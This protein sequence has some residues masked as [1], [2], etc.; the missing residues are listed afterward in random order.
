MFP[1]IIA[2]ASSVTRFVSFGYPHE[3][4]FDE[5]FYGNF[6]SHYWQG[7]YFFDQHPPFVK[8]LF[9]ALGQVFGVSRYSADWSSIGNA[10]P[11]AV[12][13]LR[14]IPMIAGA[15]LPLV[16]YALCRRLGCS[17]LA[18][19]TGATLISL[20]N[21]LVVQ[22]RFLLPDVIMLLTGFTAILAYIEYRRR[23]SGKGRHR[24]FLY[25]STILAALTLSTKW[26]GLT[27]LFLILCLEL[28]QLRED[29]KPSRGEWKPILRRFSGFA[30]IYLGVSVAIYVLLFAFHFAALPKSGPGDVF[31]TPA[32]DKTLAGSKYAADPAIAPEAF[33][34]KFIELNRAMYVANRDM[35]ATHPYSSKWYTWPIMWRPIFYWQSAVSNSTRSYIYLLGNPFIYWL[36]TISMAG[37][38]LS[39]LVSLWYKKLRLKS[40]E[41][42]RTL[43]FLILGYLAN[44]LPF[45][46]IGRVMF[47]YHYESAL[48]FSIMCIAFLVDLLPGRKKAIAVALILAL[49]LAAFIYWSPLTYGT[50]LTDQQLQAR[51]WLSSW[52]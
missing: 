18:A 10:L 11:A 7:A 42:N 32:F 45:I 2:L 49:A 33:P 3:V 20:E 25:A 19:F 52:R 51:M 27:F 16:I 21:S 40:V 4:V 6:I 5:V 26:T 14:I 23:L 34:A 13:D 46:F 44:L 36:G 48:V 8:L 9:E 17:K 47:L 43:F 28:Y 15:I 29:M 35:V 37:L 31:M 38:S 30:G 24:W 39:A 1:A 41:R 22:S 12:V 50:P